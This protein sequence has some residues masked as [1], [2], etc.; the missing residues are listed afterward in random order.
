M[1]RS[2]Y[3]QKR[4]S[5]SRKSRK[6]HTRSKNIK[7]SKGI[8]ITQCMKKYIDLDEDKGTWKT[9]SKEV[10]EIARDF[11]KNEGSWFNN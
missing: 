2:I 8:K 4:K 5:Y 6:S 9:A 7:R 10:L 11:C 3:K 1:K